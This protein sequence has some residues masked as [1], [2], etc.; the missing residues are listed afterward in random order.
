MAHFH[1]QVPGKSGPI[2]K[3]LTGEFVLNADK[4][5]GLYLRGAWTERN[6][7]T[8]FTPAMAAAMLAD[9]LYVN[10]HTARHPAGAIRGQVAGILGSAVSIFGRMPRARAGHARL[11]PLAG[12]SGLRFQGE[13]G[14]IL[15]IRIA[16]VTGRIFA[17]RRLALDASGLSGTLDLTG[18]RQGMYMAAWEERG[19]HYA[20]RFMRQ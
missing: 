20:M 17:D 2:V 1:K 5:T 11:V 19:V 8:P 12:G 4:R 14:R 16:A 18:L 15:R 10:I 13:P 9:S 7:S 6:D 3:D